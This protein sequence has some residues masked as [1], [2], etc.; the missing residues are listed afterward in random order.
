MNYKHIN[1]WCGEIAIYAAFYNIMFLHDLISASKFR[2]KNFMKVLEGGCRLQR[3]QQTIGL[4]R[5][6]S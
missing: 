4:S 6:A 3:S 5:N 1:Y 2:K